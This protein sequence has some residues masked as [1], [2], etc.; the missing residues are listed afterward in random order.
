[1]TELTLAIDQSTQGT[2]VLLINPDGTIAYKVTKGH[3]QIIS[4]HGWISH[5]LIE[6]KNNLK[7]LIHTALSH[8]TDKIVAVAI[9]NQRETAAAWDKTTAEPLALA[10]VW[11]DN[12]A[13][14]LTESIIL[15]EHAHLIKQKTGLPLSPYFTAAKFEWMQLYEP[16]VRDA[17]TA[18]NLC[19]GTIDS[20]LLYIL[21]GGIYKTE[22]SNACRTLLMN[23]D[24][25]NWDPE[26]CTLFGINI[27][28]LPQIV[29]SDSIFGETTLFGEL[30]TPIPIISILGDS[31][32]ALFAENCLQAGQIKI[33]FGTGSSIMMNTGEK[34][35]HIDGLNTSI[36]WRKN[37][38]TTYALEGN[39]NYSG[40]LITWLKN[41]L[42]IINDPSETNAM[43]EAANPN[44]TTFLIPAFSGM[45]APYNYPQLKAAL[46]GMSQLTGRNE[47]VRAALNAV[48]YQ[49][50]DV[51]NLMYQASA[52]ISS[53][54][55]V[56][57]GMI[58]NRYLMQQLANISQQSVLISS[59]QELSG[60]GA[61]MSGKNNHGLTFPPEKIYTANIH[62]QD[63]T[64]Q[65]K[66]WTSNIKQLIK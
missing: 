13:V 24:T 44:D 18:D 10:V 28:N 57:G 6:I 39:V 30:S 58:A 47:I 3:R 46:V 20:W 49:I 15:K 65:V 35:I 23:L 1:M 42:N 60:V 26:L 5:D 11:Q 41:N 61:A 40:S 50:N 25:G 17:L 27:N 7:T 21:S 34:Q 38:K 43:A 56:D 29:D 48:I 45:A 31:Q 64:K 12:R 55:H 33:T 14:S 66:L 53:T 16:A 51:M 62:Q 52:K 37:K 2:K 19:F 63:A 9:S 4:P 22:P 59:I 32:A 36:A 8:T 54:V